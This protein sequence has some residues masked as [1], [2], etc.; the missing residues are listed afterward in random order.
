MD[1]NIKCNRCNKDWNTNYVENIYKETEAGLILNYNEE[2]SK[3]YERAATAI[4]LKMYPW[5]SSYKG[6]SWKGSLTEFWNKQLNN[7]GWNFKGNLHSISHC[8]NCINK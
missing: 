4:T 8:P 3:D 1:H 6:E 7:I 2:M 5:I